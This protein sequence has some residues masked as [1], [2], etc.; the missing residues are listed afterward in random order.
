MYQKPTDKEIAESWQ[1]WQEY[2]DPRATMSH[3]EWVGM[4]IEERIELLRE[5]FPEDCDEQ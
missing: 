2:F 1:L 5:S 4:P 3:E